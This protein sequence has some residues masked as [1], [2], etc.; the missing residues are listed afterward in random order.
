M[1]FVVCDSS[2]L[3]VREGRTTRSGEGREGK[4]GS[5]THLSN[6]TDMLLLLLVD[7]PLWERPR[8]PL[9]TLHENT[10]YTTEEEGGDRKSA[11]Q[12][13]QP[14]STISSSPSF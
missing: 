9:P 6:G 3:R 4:E 1:G 2:D 12:L 8:V 13:Q 5:S 14:P 7:L 11:L 10:L